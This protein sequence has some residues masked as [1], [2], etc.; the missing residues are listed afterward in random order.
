MAFDSLE[1]LSKAL[2]L[3]IV[4]EKRKGKLMLVKFTV[5][6]VYGGEE[7]FKVKMGSLME[8]LEELTS[9]LDD[10][11]NS[12]YQMYFRDRLEN[13]L[14]VGMSGLITH[15][16]MQSNRE[17][18]FRALSQDKVVEIV[19]DF[20]IGKFEEWWAPDFSKTIKGLPKGPPVFGEGKDPAKAH[21]LHKAVEANKL[22][23]V[24]ELVRT[25]EDI[26]ALDDDKY[27]ALVIA[28]LLGHE[29]I[30][31]FL[32]EQGA[33]PIVSKKSLGTSMVKLADEFPKIQEL[34]KQRGIE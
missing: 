16:T 9:E 26:D 6:H 7:E 21:R 22:V 29:K 18:H 28:V 3:D 5:G 8:L 32:L 33:K 31:R 27:S 1:I 2:D 4:E 24:K 10:G 20:L 15:N 13:S 17:L 19:H 30:C 34:L 11:D 25:G 23:L 12:H 14:T